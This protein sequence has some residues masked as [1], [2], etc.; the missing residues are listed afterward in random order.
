MSYLMKH[1][2]NIVALRVECA[3]EADTA[4]EAD[5]D[6]M[7]QRFHELNTTFMNERDDMFDKY[8]AV[9]SPHIKKVEALEKE[10]EAAAARYKV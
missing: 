5:L 2:F 7:A 4:T 6:R 3:E 8:E 1:Y 10:M 9:V